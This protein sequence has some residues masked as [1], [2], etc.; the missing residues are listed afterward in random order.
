MHVA[1]AGVARGQHGPLRVIE[2]E[3]GDLL[4][5]EHAVLHAGAHGAAPIGA[6][7]RQSAQQRRARLRAGARGRARARGLRRG[8]RRTIDAE[9]EAV[10]RQMQHSLAG[11][12]MLEGIFRGR[13]AGE[14]DRRVSGL[15]LVDAG[16]SPLRIPAL[17]DPLR[18]D[19]GRRQLTEAGHE[20]AARLRSAANV[21][22]AGPVA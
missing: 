14:T 3:P 16:A 10:R 22:R 19:L 13:G 6:R 17:R 5:R 7:E 18:F 20:V 1:D 2:I 15:H 11:G 21:G 8:R 4:G 9:I 12:E